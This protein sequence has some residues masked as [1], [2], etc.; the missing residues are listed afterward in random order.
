MTRLQSL[1]AVATA[2]TI[3]T[4]TALSL[5]P[6]RSLHETHITSLRSTRPSF[7]SRSKISS[8]SA[9]KEK[10]DEPYFATDDEEVVGKSW[11][12]N[13]SAED[14]RASP[15]KKLTPTPPPPPPKPVLKSNND[16]N[17][18]PSM[19]DNFLG[20]ILNPTIEKNVPSQVIQGAFLNGVFVTLLT[21]FFMFGPLSISSLLTIVLA[22]NVGIITSYISITEG[23]AGDFIRSLGVATM[24]VTDGIMEQIEN[25]KG[26]KKKIGN[27]SNNNA[28]KVANPPKVTSPVKDMKKT[29]VVSEPTQQLTDGMTAEEAEK[30]REARVSGTPDKE[31]MANKPVAVIED[32]MNTA[33][34]AEAVRLE[35]L[36][37]AEEKAAAKKKEDELLKAAAEEEKAAAAE[38]AKLKAEQE[39]KLQAEREAAELKEAAEAKAR[40]EE[41]QAKLQAEREAAQLK[42]EEEAMA[43]A[44]EEAKLKAEQEAEEQ[45]KLQLKAE[46]EARARA[47]EE[48]KLQAERE[49][50]ELKAKEEEEA[51]A[52]A[53]EERRIAAETEQRR[54]EEQAEAAREAVRLMEEQDALM[55][56]DDEDYDMEYE[57]DVEYEGDELSDEDWE[58]SVRLANEL[59]GI[60]TPSVTESIGGDVMDAI[61]DELLQYE[62][63]NL[64]QEEEDALG[65][66]ARE[67]VAKYEEEMRMKAR[68]KEQV[69]SSWDDDMVTATPPSEEVI[70]DVEEE[71]KE[72]PAPQTSNGDYSKMTVAELK[73]E[74][75][76]KGLKVSGKKAELIERLE[77]S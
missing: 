24:E 12:V 54:L 17:D 9:V 49:A 66:A 27:V 72:A 26:E 47:E 11:P 50:A 74:L 57:G 6:Q 40:E 31:E 16:D 59:Q 61:G 65:K 36:R 10:E 52:R 21:S 48:A 45:A 18:G 2:Y 29:M 7:L 63:D 69:R 4:T 33:E 62:I 37:V 53:E 19:I 34:D 51:M 44:E 60:A 14:K 67:A 43:R 38:A 3:K 71:V 55:D 23:I 77:S 13:P 25:V 56:D 22:A 41:K 70:E 58:A 35:R 5:T 39:A 46:E 64:T 30:I 76:S 75:R 73:E 42:A 68:E 28:L 1:V 32:G 20:P 8:L 15:N